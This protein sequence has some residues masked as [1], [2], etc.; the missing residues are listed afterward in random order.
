MSD[1]D[2]IGPNRQIMI[3]KKLSLADTGNQK[4][5][6]KKCLG[7]STNSE[8]AMTIRSV[9]LSIVVIGTSKSESPFE[10]RDGGREEVFASLRYHPLRRQRKL[11]S[12]TL[13]IGA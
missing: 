13:R 1:C 2:S 9:A 3:E 8:L 7:A 10:R 6:K 5:K 4:K 11:G 12:L